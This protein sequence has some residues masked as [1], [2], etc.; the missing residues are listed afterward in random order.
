VRL[1]GLRLVAQVASQV[2]KTEARIGT[3]TLF[4]SA[5]SWRHRRSNHSGPMINESEP[6]DEHYLKAAALPF[7]VDLM[8]AEQPLTE[9]ALST[10]CGMRPLREE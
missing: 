3:L 8:A 9:G 6:P 7:I 2:L 5:D 1:E 10:V 4:R